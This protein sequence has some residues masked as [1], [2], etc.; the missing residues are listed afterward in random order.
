[1]ALYN[2]V[3]AYT[4]TKGALDV[5][6][7]LAVPGYLD[8]TAVPNAA[9]VSYGLHEG[10]QSEVGHGTWTSA[11]KTLSRDTVLASTNS[12]AKIPLQ[13]QAQVYITALAEDV[14]VVKASIAW[15]ETSGSDAS[16]KLGVE[17]LPF[18][19]SEYFQKHIYNF[20]VEVP[21]A[22]FTDIFERLLFCPS[23]AIGTV[24]GNGI[25]DI[26]DCKYA[27][28]KRDLPAFQSAR[29]ACAVPFFVMAIWD[30]QRLPQ[31]FDRLKHFMGKL[32]MPTHED[33][34][35]RG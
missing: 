17:N 23:F 33:P 18:F 1:M 32:R 13:G 4:A 29:V 28:R 24:I 2:L 7:G 35:L 11:T 21:S 3:R 16:G 34:F 25:P 9:V 20:R 8:F 31:V 27:C 12:G 30:I 22:L 26:C 5:V 15:V 19:A 6:V 10:S 14:Q